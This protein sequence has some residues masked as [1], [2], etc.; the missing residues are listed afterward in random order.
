[1]KIAHL[2]QVSADQLLR[3]D[4]DLPDEHGDGWQE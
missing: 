2:F 3:D 1:M 4:L